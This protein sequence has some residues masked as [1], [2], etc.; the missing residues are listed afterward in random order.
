ML[1]PASCLYALQLGDDCLVLAQ[2]LGE[3]SAR[4]PELEEDVA[5][6]NIALDLLGQGRSFLTYAAD[7]DGRGRDEDDLAFLREERDFLNCQLV[8][9]PNRDFA[10][11]VAR[12]LLFCSY[13]FLLYERLCRSA[14]TTL[15]AVSAK[16]LKEVIYHRDHARLWTLRLG[17]GTDESRRRMAA[18]LEFVWPYA[19]ELF[20]DD[21]RLEEL[22]AAGFAVEPRTLRLEW[23]TFVM[24]VIAEATLAVP[25]TA[26]KPSGG[27]RGV[28]T[29]AFSYLLGEMQYLHRAH[30]GARW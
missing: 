12:Q 28:H 29:E 13:K 22:V 19:A 8:E 21:D 4:A 11:T 24:G 16:A 20:E 14:D 6:T 23:E 9:L 5:L 10:C 18:G 26:W 27:R 15:A 7:L 1:A 2:R 3:W 25:E 30:P 17:D